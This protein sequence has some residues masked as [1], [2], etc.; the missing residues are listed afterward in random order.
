M[1]FAYM[2]TLFALCSLWWSKA[3]FTVFLL[4]W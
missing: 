2:A 4:F 1:I 3:N